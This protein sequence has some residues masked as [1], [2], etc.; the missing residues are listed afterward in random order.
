MTTTV[1]RDG[2]FASDTLVQCGECSVGENQ[3]IFVN[4]EYV[5]AGSGDAGS[6]EPFLKHLTSGEKQEFPD[7]YF[8]FYDFKK[9]KL[10]RNDQGKRSFLITD[11]FTA[12]GSGFHLAIGAMEMGAS[13][14][15]AVKIAMKRDGGSG[16][17]VVAYDCINQKW[18]KKF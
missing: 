3:K 12:D 10:F 1:F 18:L 16:G 7:C 11:K 8:L 5:V 13:A 17:R 14:I 4:K 9:K 2:I 15:E 6:A